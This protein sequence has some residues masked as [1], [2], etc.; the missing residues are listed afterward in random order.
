MPFL[1]K[2]DSAIEELK[3][4]VGDEELL[5]DEELRELI[6]PEIVTLNVPSILEILFALFLLFTAIVEIGYYYGGLGFEY[7]I[8]ALFFIICMF[9]SFIVAFGMIV[10]NKYAAF[11]GAGK[12]IF[13][14]F[15]FLYSVFDYRRLAQQASSEKIIRLGNLN[16]EAI[17]ESNMFINL[18][19]LIFVLIMALSIFYM[20]YNEGHLDKLLRKQRIPTGAVNSVAAV[21]ELKGK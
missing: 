2:D 5:S 18:A 21:A 12:S 1:A 4:D 10:K 8:V 14:I 9:I 16:Q 7:V 15:Y 13:F 11:L 19:L 6:K 17:Y 20:L 3:K